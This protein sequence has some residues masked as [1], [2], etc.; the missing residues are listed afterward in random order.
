[1]DIETLLTQFPR[2]EPFVEGVFAITEERL[3]PLNESSEKTLRQFTGKSVL[4]PL[5]GYIHLTR[6]EAAFL[7]TGLFQ[8][9]RGIRQLGLAHLVYARRSRLGGAKNPWPRR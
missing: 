3:S 6:W 4:D 5:L 1:M 8:R 7:E 9:L 2:L